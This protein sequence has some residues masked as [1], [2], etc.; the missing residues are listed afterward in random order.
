MN[1][2]RAA[3]L[4][5]VLAAAPAGAA[6]RTYPVTDFNTI[7]VEGPFAVTL[8]TGL[9]SRV[10]ATGSPQALER[11]TVEVGGRPRRIGI[12]HSA[13]GGYPGQS[14]EPVRIEAA[15]LDLA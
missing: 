10:R 14:P 6:E 12:N 15:T 5:A 13:W 7:K 2:L 11:L 3:A 1:R 9:S 4:A 8:A